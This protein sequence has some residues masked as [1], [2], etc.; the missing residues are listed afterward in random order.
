MGVAVYVLG[1]PSALSQTVFLNQDFVW[2]VGLMLSGLFFA[3][4]V[5]R[6]GVSRF[7][8][9]LINTDDQDLHLGVW[10]EWAIRLVVVEAVVLIVWWL[11]QV[12][13][14]P[15]F[16]ASGLGTLALEWG[17]VLGVLVL[18]NRRLV[19]GRAE[20]ATVQESSPP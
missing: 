14:E 13:T 9:E 10:W 7:R 1:L 11:W 4:A 5:L 19:R 16:S 2:S 18:V 20:G 3:L 12:R 8:R 17:V 6:Y 15:L